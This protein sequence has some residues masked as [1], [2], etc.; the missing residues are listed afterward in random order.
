MV[1]MYIMI[2]LT[3]SSI[4]ELDSYDDRNFRVVGSKVNSDEKVLNLI[5]LS[6]YTHNICILPYL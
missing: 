2:G 3:V 6:L 1:C 5:N 4:R